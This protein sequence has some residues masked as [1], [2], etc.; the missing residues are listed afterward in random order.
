MLGT[1]EI[2]RVSEQPADF[3]QEQGPWNAGVSPAFS[4][5]QLPGLCCTL[6]TK[7]SPFAGS[8][9]SGGCGGTWG[10]DPLPRRQQ[11][12]S[13]LYPALPWGIRGE[14]EGGLY[15]QKQQVKEKKGK[16]PERDPK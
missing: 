2:Q 11:W 7:V 13:S 5:V 6:R 16:P 8:G 10:R 1:S 9:D 15:E 12:R 3:G 4:F 14:G